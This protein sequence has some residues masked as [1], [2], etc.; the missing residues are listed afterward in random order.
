MD[1]QLCEYAKSHRIV[2]LT[3]ENCMG[4]ELYLNKAIKR[5]HASVLI[6][7]SWVTHSGECQLLCP[8]QHF[9]EARVARSQQFLPTAM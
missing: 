6:I 4:C 9:G 5:Y 7:L 3:W 2:H 8:K 1:A